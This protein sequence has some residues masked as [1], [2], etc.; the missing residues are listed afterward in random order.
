MSEQ[1]L[2]IRNFRDVG[3]ACTGTTTKDQRI[4]ALIDLAERVPMEGYVVTPEVVA[5]ADDPESIALIL[6]IYGTA[7]VRSG[8]R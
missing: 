3:P 4:K 8:L 2:M 1:R 5:S 7:V 6:L